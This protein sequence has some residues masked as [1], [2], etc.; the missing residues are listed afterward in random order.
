MNRVKK[1]YKFVFIFLLSILFFAEFFHPI[2]AINDDLGRHILL[3]EVIVR[4]HHV[5][6]TNLLSYIYPNYPYI[7]ISWL[8]EV[9]YY[10]LFL[11]GGFDLLLITNTI[12]I[13]FAFGLL[14]FYSTKKNPLTLA[15]LLSV[16]LYLLLLGLRSDI[17]PEV[18]SMVCMSLF[19]IILFSYLEKRNRYIWFLIP[20]ELLWVNTHIYFFVGPVLIIL[21][22]VDEMISHNFRRSGIKNL[23]FVFIATLLVTLINPNSIKGALFPLTVLHNYGFPIV[24]NQSLLTLFVIYHAS[25][26]LLPV[27]GVIALFIVL[28]LAR[29]NTQPIDWLLAVVFSIATVIIFRNILLFVFATFL[30]FSTQLNFLFT[31]YKANVKK[32]SRISYIFYYPLSLLLIMLFIAIFISEKGVGIGVT[33]YGKNATDFLQAHNIKG[34]LYNNLNIGGYLAYRIYPQQVFLDNRPEAYPVSFFQK[35]YIPMQDDPNIFKKLDQQY[36]FN[37]IIIEHWDNTPW[38]YPLLNYLINDSNFKLIYLD[39]YVVLLIRNTG[40]NRELI[41]QYHITKNNLKA[42]LTTK[43]QNLSNY[44]FFF[45]KVG[46]TKNVNAT[47]SLIKKSDP[48]LCVLKRYPLEKTHIQQYILENNLN[49]NCSLFIDRKG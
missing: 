9:I 38:G 20:I 35:I 6:Q 44:L 21:F 46:W 16:T 48:Q 10:F 5:P 28:F 4:T 8:A 29:K 2:T 26:I 15:T 13:A 33:A 47:L 42:N 39:P 22:L 31:K 25:E 45:E 27:S 17:R 30:T 3:G 41:A 24:E 40:T 18:V 12:L 49:K 36:Q 23:S 19:M 14:I 37:A 1:L 7:A 11:V 34:P 43:T 32:L